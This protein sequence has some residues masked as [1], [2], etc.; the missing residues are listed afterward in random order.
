M[1]DGQEVVLSKRLADVVRRLV[2]IEERIK[3]GSK[4]V[5][6]ALREQSVKVSIEEEV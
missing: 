1:I 4:V 2:R 6:I 3:D 5:R